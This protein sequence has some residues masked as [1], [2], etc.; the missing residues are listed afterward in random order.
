MLQK[1]TFQVV[2]LRTDHGVGESPT[3]K[4]DEVVEYNGTEQHKTLP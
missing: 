1:R 2:V 3:S 4:P